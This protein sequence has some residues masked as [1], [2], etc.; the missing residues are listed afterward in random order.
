MVEPN[1]NETGGSY[2]YDRLDMWDPD[3][4]YDEYGGTLYDWNQ[5]YPEIIDGI[6]TVDKDTPILV[7]GNGYSGVVWLPYLKV[8][9]DKRVVYIAHQYAPHQ[10]THQYTFIECSYPGKCDIDWDG[11]KEQFDKAWLTDFLLL[12]DVFAD[13][14]NVPVAVNEFGV[15]R[16]IPGAAQFMDDEMGLF[17]EKGMNY[18]LW[19]WETSWEPHTEEENAFNFLYGPD[20]DNTTAVPNE[21]KDVI[22]NYWSHNTVRPSTFYQ[23]STGFIPSFLFSLF[24]ILISYRLFISVVLGATLI[25]PYPVASGIEKRLLSTTIRRCI[26]ECKKCCSSFDFNCFGCRLHAAD[27]RIST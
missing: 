11:Q 3:E 27:R 9:R 25:Q 14:H 2:V 17:E 13:N 16:W 22:T 23:D 19:E 12:I 26:N 8:V 21:L 18:A 6:R 7:G 24:R 10:Y 5:L 15:I 4:F 1:S 20:P